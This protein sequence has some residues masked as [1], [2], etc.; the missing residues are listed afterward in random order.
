MMFHRRSRRLPKKSCA[1]VC[2]RLGIALALLFTTI[3]PFVGLASGQTSNGTD[4]ST[5][6]SNAIDRFIHGVSD[7]RDHAIL[8]QNIPKD[9]KR[10]IGIIK[11][12]RAPREKVDQAML[13]TG[14]G[15]QEYLALQWSGRLYEKRIEF[16]R[17]DREPA[18]KIRAR[19]LRQFKAWYIDFLEPS[20]R[21]VFEDEPTVVVLH[22]SLGGSRPDNSRIHVIQMKRNTVDIVPPGVGRPINLTDLDGDGTYEL[23]TSD[24]IADGGRTGCGFCSIHARVVFERRL[25]RFVPAC[26]KH[27]KSMLPKLE[28]HARF[29]RSGDD[30][31]WTASKMI[32]IALI[33]AQFGD[34]TKAAEGIDWAVARLHETDERRP[35]IS[36]QEIDVARN[37]FGRMV[38]QAKDLSGEQCPLS[39]QNVSGMTDAV[40]TTTTR[41]TAA[42]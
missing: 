28:T 17:I 24:D 32:E 31:G 7:V 9:V 4:G 16:H 23:V 34:F 39:A 13:L 38:Q 21:S 40:A 33:Y 41:T 20:G 35:Q 6:N 11:A 30:V 15:G 3:P 29:V 10:V 22:H 25:G 1:K 19:F 8:G 12:N 26:R 14:E 37:V 27:R 2:S 36:M 5:K 42:E 18:G